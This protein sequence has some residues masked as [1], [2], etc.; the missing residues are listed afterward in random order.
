MSFLSRLGEKRTGRPPDEIDSIV[1]HLRALLNAR[2]GQS[3]ASPDYGLPDFTD[4]VHG[5]PKSIP[6]LQRS[7]GRAIERFEPRLKDVAVQHIPDDEALVLRFE[8]TAKLVSDD[9]RLKVR[10]R[11]S[12][13]GKFDLQ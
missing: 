10:T 13:G 11:V 9:R 5:V 6:G 8:I 2:Q 3:P 12:A 1:E 7:I 4:V